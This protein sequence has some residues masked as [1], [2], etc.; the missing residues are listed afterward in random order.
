MYKTDFEKATEEDVNRFTQLDDTDV[1]SAIKTWQNADDFVLSY[2]CKNS[3][4]EKIPKTV[5]SSQKFEESEILEKNRTCQS[6]I[7]HRKWRSI[8]GTNQQNFA[9]L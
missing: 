2:F 8:G 6:E 7:W 1:L 3:G 5:F 9:T 4:S